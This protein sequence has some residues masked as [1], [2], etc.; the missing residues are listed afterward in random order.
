MPPS[1]PAT[2][3]HLFETELGWM[4]VAWRGD[5]LARLTSGHPTLA[6]A[7]GGMEVDVAQAGPPNARQRKMVARLTSFAAGQP[8]DLLDLPIDL[9]RY[10]PFSRRVVIG[11]REIPY[12]ETRTYAEL[13]SVAGSPR[14]AR[15]VGNV[16]RTNPIALVVPCHRVVGAGSSLGGYS[17]PD[18][19]TM[20]RRLLLLEQQGARK[21]GRRASRA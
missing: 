11:C 21:N 10:S 2:A 18:G 20:K 13:A 17:A 4:A 5:D 16:M 12:G 9:T 3:M 8:D 19:L 6:D 14:A 1:D 7:M 15:A